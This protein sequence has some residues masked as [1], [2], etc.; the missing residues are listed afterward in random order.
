MT[1]IRFHLYA[2]A[3]GTGFRASALA[4]L[5]PDTSTWERCRP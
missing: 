4:S 3:C 5:T 2:C 1:T